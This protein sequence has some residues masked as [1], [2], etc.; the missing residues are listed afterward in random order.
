MGWRQ[1]SAKEA[2][3]DGIQFL[4]RDC[5]PKKTGTDIAALIEH[6]HKWQGYQEALDDIT[7]I[8]T[9]IPKTEK[10]LDEAPLNG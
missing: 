5:A 2:F 10:T 1:F 7:D 4:R 6:T 8:L 3:L 9:N